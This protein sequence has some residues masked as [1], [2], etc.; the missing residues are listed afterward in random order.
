MRSVDMCNL[1]MLR[2]QKI[3]IARCCIWRAC[4]P[5][6]P[7]ASAPFDTFGCERLPSRNQSNAPR[8]TAAV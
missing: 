7:T 5:L 4:L 8:P 2:P 6:C 1:A 3:S